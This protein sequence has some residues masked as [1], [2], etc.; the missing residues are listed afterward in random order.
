[1]YLPYDT[2]EFLQWVQSWKYWFFQE[3]KKNLKCDLIWLPLVQGSNAQP[4]E[5]TW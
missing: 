2:F 4:T 1:M 3:T 5:L